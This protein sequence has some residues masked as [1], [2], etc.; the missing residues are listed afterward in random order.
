M[1]SEVTT[2]ELIAAL[3]KADPDGTACVMDANGDPVWFPYRKPPYY[4]GPTH[5]LIVGDDGK[6][7]G[8]KIHRS[9]PDKVVL[10]ARPLVELLH[11]NPDANV[12]LSALTGEH[13]AGWTLAVE[14]MRNEAREP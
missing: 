13:L 9:G 5:S 14:R 10:Y 2:A 4:D 1:G 11:D 8:Y 6:V 3:Q 12:D 7:S